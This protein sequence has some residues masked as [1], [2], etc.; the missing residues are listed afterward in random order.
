MISEATSAYLA[1]FCLE[2]WPSE[3][4]RKAGRRPR[5]D[6]SC[7]ASWT[8]SFP[9]QAPMESMSAQDAAR[10][11]ALSSSAQPLRRNVLDVDADPVAGQRIRRVDRG[12]RQLERACDRQDGDGERGVSARLRTEHQLRDA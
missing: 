11:G 7:D 8:T 3:D 4:G 2:D 12:D 10:L 6:R 5:T 1:E 9:Y